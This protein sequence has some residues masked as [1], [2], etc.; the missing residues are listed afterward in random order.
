MKTARKS[1]SDFPPTWHN[2][3][4]DFFLPRFLLPSK[5]VNSNDWV[6][7]VFLCPLKLQVF[8]L[9]KFTAPLLLCLLFM[10]VWMTTTGT[11]APRLGASI[12]EGSSHSSTWLAVGHQLLGI[13]AQPELMCQG[14]GCSWIWSLLAWRFPPTCM[15]PSCLLSPC[16]LEAWRRFSNRMMATESFVCFC[17]LTWWT[18][19]N[20]MNPAEI[21]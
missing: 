4:A 5:T 2:S 15:K 19:V 21:A 3:V 10:P 17:A 18:L 1:S 6:A 7:W 14:C 13:R 12:P 16:S 11:G 20:L 9:W 8:V